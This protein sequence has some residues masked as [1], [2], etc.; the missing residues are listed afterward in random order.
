MRW[1][2]LR[3]GLV[4]GC[5]AQIELFSVIHTIPQVQVDQVLVWNACEL[6]HALEVPN[7]VS[8]HPDC[9]LL[10]EPGSIGVLPAFHFRQIVF[11]FHNFSHG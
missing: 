10:F 9:D 4:S 2:P 1:D 6:C 3:V 8:P 5:P 11:G 7:D